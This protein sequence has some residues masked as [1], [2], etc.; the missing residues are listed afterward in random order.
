MIANPPT[1]LIV[2]VALFLP[3][4]AFAQTGSSVVQNLTVEVRPIT[5]IAVSGNPGSLFIT[6]APHGADVVSVSD[7]RSRYSMVTNMDNMKIVASI[8][9]EMPVGTKLMVKLESSS[10]LSN[11]AVDISNARAPVEVVTGLGRGSDLNQAI[12]YTFAANTSVGSIS[13]DSRVV[14]LTLTN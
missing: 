5:K 8:S 10:G 6:D 13:A 11:G 7:N 1:R 14:T 12:T 4:V 3:I 9:H 2:C